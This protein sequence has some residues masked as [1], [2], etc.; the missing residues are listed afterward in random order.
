MFGFDTSSLILTLGSYRKKRAFLSDPNAFSLTLTPDIK[1]EKSSYQLPTDYRDDIQTIRERI[2]QTNVGYHVLYTKHLRAFTCKFGNR[3]SFPY[4]FIPNLLGIHHIA[5]SFLQTREPFDINFEPLIIETGNLIHAAL[6]KE[7]LEAYY[8][9]NRGEIIV[10]ASSMLS[11]HDLQAIFEKHAFTTGFYPI[12]DGSR[13]EFDDLKIYLSDESAPRELPFILPSEEDIYTYLSKHPHI[14]WMIIPNMIKPIA[15][16]LACKEYIPDHTIYILARALLED[17]ILLG[18]AE[19]IT[20]EA[21][22][23]QCPKGIPSTK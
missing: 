9:E 11:M 2:F 20:L 7:G 17:N 10:L 15:T 3:H 16:F 6:K 21:V 5:K 19:A 13:T 14:N 4:E 18:H 23:I 8:F 22:L 12:V 1:A